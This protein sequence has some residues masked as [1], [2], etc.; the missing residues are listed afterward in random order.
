MQVFTQWITEIV[1]YLVLA[2]LADALLPS[3]LMKK[4]ARLVLAILL[5]LIIIDPLLQLLKV[6]PHQIVQSVHQQMNAG[7]ETEQLKAEIEEKKNEI[8]RGQDAYTLQ[9][10]EEAVSGQLKGPLEE[11]KVS[12]E[13]ADFEF[14]TEPYSVESLDKLILTLSSQ[15]E[16]SVV[17]EVVISANDQTASGTNHPNEADIKNLVAGKLGL[18]VQ[19]I[20]IRWEEDHE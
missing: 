18:N 9:Q 6:N 4:Y 14:S 17:E 7:F 11:E 5:L 12:I 16:E 8:M 20:E 19:Q 15:E 2:I 1:L 13:T 3:G 10:V